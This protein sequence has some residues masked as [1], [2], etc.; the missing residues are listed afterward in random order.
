VSYEQ[1]EGI[2]T[3]TLDDGKVNVMSLAMQDAIHGALDRA[4]S[5]RG[6]VVLLGRPGVFS[7]G[8]DLGVLTAAGTEAVAMVKGGF[9]LSLRLLA[10]PRPVIIGCTGH[11]IAM[12]AFLLLS[13]DLRIGVDGPYRLV[14][15]EVAIGLTMPRTAVEILRQRLAPAAFDR[16]AI[17]AEP[18]SPTEAIAAGFL[19]RV[20]APD[21]LGAAARAAA[22]TA[23]GLDV[24][25][26]A[27]TK[28]RVRAPVL[29]AIR[30]A[31][32]RDEAELTTSLVAT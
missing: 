9:E 31:I 19:D 13:G 22:V 7:A 14:A 30:A 1:A 26:H 2:A 25:A 29:E 18:C 20:V 15:N 17:L 32:V 27:A 16:S 12:G 5:D 11:A 6:P 10:F 3:I 21:E 4:Q 8:F 28:Q 24:A 23:A